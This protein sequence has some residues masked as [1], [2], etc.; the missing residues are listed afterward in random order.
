[1]EISIRIPNFDSLSTDGLY[2]RFGKPYKVPIRRVDGKPGEP[3]APPHA[4]YPMGLGMPAN[5]V[6]NP[7][8]LIS[9]YGTSFIVSQTPSPIL[10]T[11]ALYSPPERL[12]Q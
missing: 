6:D 5:E 1:M 3:H 11:P 9:D 2:Q 10:H 8:I 12:F 4:I 7:E